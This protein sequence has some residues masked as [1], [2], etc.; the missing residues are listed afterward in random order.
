L[1]TR[2]RGGG[3]GEGEAEDT[4]GMGRG[5]ARLKGLLLRV[6]GW[7]GGWGKRGIW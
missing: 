4:G 6:K 2:A 7:M 5:G 1:A 3:G